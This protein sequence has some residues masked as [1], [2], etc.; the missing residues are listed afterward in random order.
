VVVVRD[1]ATEKTTPSGL[2]ATAT[3]RESYCGSVVAVG[4]GRRRDDGSHV[5]CEIK[6]CDRV[7]WGVEG[8]AEV[9]VG[10]V[11]YLVFGEDQILAKFRVEE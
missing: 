2:V 9:E 11:T 6:V 10:D 5:E 3:P 4:P 1:K 7:I 8:G